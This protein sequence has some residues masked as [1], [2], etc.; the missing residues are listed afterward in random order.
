MRVFRRFAAL[1]A[2]L[3]SLASAGVAHSQDYP[4]RAIRL[5]VAFPAGGPTDFVARLL[6]DKLKGILGQS[7]LVENKSGANAAIGADYVAK[8]DPDGYTLFFTTISAVVMNPH[9]RANLPYDPVRDFAPV[10]R[11][12]LTTEVLVVSTKSPIKSAKELIDLAK[13]KNGALPMASTGVGSLP[14]LA[15][16]LFQQS[17]GIKVV[18]VPYRGAAP[19]VTDILGGQVV[20]SFL[21]LPVVMPQIIGGNLRAL[22]TA[23]AKRDPVLPDLPTFDE[24][25]YRD[26]YADNWYAL[27]APAKTPAPVIAKL[28]AAFRTAL[29]DPEVARRLLDAGAVP[30]PTTPEELGDILKADLARW[31][32]IIRER[33]IKT[34]E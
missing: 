3:A 20:G 33:N 26:V 29:T 27:F 34:T 21:D 22:G 25:G 17:T 5:V 14:H 9:L 6:A 8:S 23:S 10:T 1:C 12:V 2:A 24:Q 4:A 11:L 32:K 31:G 13:E 16:E 30:A 28:N 19:A 7:V 15:L 18:H